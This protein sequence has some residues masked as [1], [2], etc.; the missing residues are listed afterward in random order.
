MKKWFLI[1]YCLL[2]A[3]CASQAPKVTPLATP[4]PTPLT[5]T[6]TPET[7]KDDTIVKGHIKQIL[8]YLHKPVR[9]GGSK[10]PVDQQ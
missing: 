1:S 2:L 8:A 5:S 7:V 6:P 4:V 10:Y 3:G 9:K